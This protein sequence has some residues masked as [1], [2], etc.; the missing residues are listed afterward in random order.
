MVSLN[1]PALQSTLYFYTLHILSLANNSFHE[2]QDHSVSCVVWGLSLWMVEHE[3]IMVTCH[4]EEDR[5]NSNTPSMVQ[6]NN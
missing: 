1:K 2:T 5:K 6:F 4:K 3:L